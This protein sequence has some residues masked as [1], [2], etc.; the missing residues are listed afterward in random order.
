MCFNE[1]KEI[2]L[3]LEQRQ[4]KVKKD[5][6]CKDADNRKREA[7]LRMGIKLERERLKREKILGGRCCDVMYASIE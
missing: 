4:T 7:W 1:E 2:E 5:L 6:S 3:I